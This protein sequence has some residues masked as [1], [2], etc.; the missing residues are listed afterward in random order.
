[1]YGKDVKEKDV[2]VDLKTLGNVHK[3]TLISP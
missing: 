2:G 3:Y 1:M